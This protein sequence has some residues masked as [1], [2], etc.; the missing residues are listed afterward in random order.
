[1]FFCAGT[2]GPLVLRRLDSSQ[3]T[4]LALLGLQHEHSRLWAV[5]TSV[6]MCQSSAVLWLQ[7]QKEA[8]LERTWSSQAQSRI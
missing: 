6:T 3:A 7:G 4:P 8:P 1:M 5:S 2:Q